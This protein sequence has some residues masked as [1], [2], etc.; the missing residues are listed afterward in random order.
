MEFCLAD[1]AKIALPATGQ[2]R[3][4]YFYYCASNS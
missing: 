3:L 1:G 2:T 4:F